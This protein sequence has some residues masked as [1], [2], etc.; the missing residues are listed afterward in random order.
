MYSLAVTDIANSSALVDE[1]ITVF[2][3]IALYWKTPPN[4]LKQRPYKLYRVSFSS[5]N[6]KSLKVRY[7]SLAKVCLSYLIA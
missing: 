6:A 2:P 7:I 5:A 3:F 4:S 1:V